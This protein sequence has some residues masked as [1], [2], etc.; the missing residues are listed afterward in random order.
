MGQ[1][2]ELRDAEAEAQEASKKKPLILQMLQK[3][4]DQ[5]VREDY[6]AIFETSM[7]GGNFMEED[8]MTILGKEVTGTALSAYQKLDPAIPY[9]TFKSTLLVRLGY[10]DAKARRTVWR[11]HPSDQK[12]P[13]SHLTPIICADNHLAQQVNNRKDHVFKQ[14]R[15]A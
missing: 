8:W 1:A 14:F 13:G 3:L 9:Q 10:T 15:G 2:E 5:T 11:S 7:V 6:L 4:D 12:S